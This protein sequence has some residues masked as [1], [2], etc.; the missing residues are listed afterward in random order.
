MKERVAPLV[1]PG[2]S[3]IVRASGSA[4]RLRPP[5][6][7]H[8]W[9]DYTTVATILVS[10][11]WSRHYVGQHAEEVA[12]PGFAPEVDE[13]LVD[14]ER[15]AEVGVDPHDAMPPGVKLWVVQAAG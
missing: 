1:T 11:C 4:S 14:H 3:W 7:T 13:P 8:A 9:G 15:R 2:E 5:A 10:L 12:Q 6:H